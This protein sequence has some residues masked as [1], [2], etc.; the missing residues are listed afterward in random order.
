MAATGTTENPGVD[1][2]TAWAA[3]ESRD[4]RY[5]GIFVYAVR[6]SG[7]YCR[8]SCASRPHRANVTFYSTTS[9]AEAAGFRACRRCNPEGTVVA[10]R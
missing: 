6:T 9:A 3:V 4:A 10:Q 2:A 8:P 5:D 7:V 1:D